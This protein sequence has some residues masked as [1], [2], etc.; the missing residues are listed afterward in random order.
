MA[1]AIAKKID[2]Q[3]RQLR[4]SLWPDMSDKLWHYQTSQ[5]WLNVP[6]AMPLLLRAMDMLS[7]K[8]KPVSATY[9]DLWCRTYNNS[10]VVVSN[11]LDM[12]FCSG[13]SGERGRHTWI[14]RIRQLE[15]SGFILVEPG[16]SGPVNYVLLKNP[17]HVLRRY[18]DEDKLPPQVANALRARMADIGATDLDDE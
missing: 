13:F 1:T 2:K 15:V 16:P 14:A 9:L 5:G 17:F 7:P 11:P 18:I 10:F 3:R 4:D 6:R 8:G 12:A